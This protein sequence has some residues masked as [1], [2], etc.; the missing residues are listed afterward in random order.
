MT[1]G[2]SIFCL[3]LGA[4]LTFAVET[5]STEGIKVNN[6]GIILMVI[7]LIGL[8]LYAL[9]WGP[10]SRRAVPPTTVIE[11]RPVVQRVVHERVVERPVVPVETSQPVVERRIYD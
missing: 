11:D 3:A 9:V 10:R 5:D 8:A 4:I 6:V 7:G 1:V 2:A